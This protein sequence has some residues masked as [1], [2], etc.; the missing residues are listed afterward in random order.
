MNLWQKISAVMNDVEYLK[1]D[2]VVGKGSKSEYKAIS[3]EKVTETVRVSF[4][5]HGLVLLPVEQVH[6]CET[7]ET[8][9]DYGKAGVR[10]LATVDVKYK[11]V[12]IET[13]EHEFIVSSGTG[14]DSGDKAVGKAMTYAYKYALLRT[15]MIP[16][17]EDPDKI[18]SPDNQPVGQQKPPSQPTTPKPNENAVKGQE[19]PNTGTETPANISPARMSRLYAIASKKG[20]TEAQVNEAI[21]S[22]YHVSYPCMMTVAQYNTAVKAYEDMPDVA[23]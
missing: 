19:T 1:K 12:D 7:R 17:G 2:D 22:K 6:S 14:E 3:E 16:T 4:I 13:G 10:R 9:N 11:L 15:L 18:A 21:K 23:K 5:K 20:R 8:V